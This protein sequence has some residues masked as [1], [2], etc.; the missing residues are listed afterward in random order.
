MRLSFSEL[1]TQLRD[2]EDRLAL[3]RRS[4]RT[5]PIVV[6]ALEA[7]VADLREALFA[8][9]RERAETFAA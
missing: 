9:R 3:A 6:A 7:E 1:R 2:A 5:S 4:P 8:R